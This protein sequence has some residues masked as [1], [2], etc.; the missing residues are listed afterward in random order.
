MNNEPKHSEEPNSLNG[1]EKTDTPTPQYIVANVHSQS[2]GLFKTLGTLGSENLNVDLNG[3]YK[4]EQ[5]DVKHEF[6]VGN[7]QAEQI[8]QCDNDQDDIS[9]KDEPIDSPHSGDHFESTLVAADLESL[10]IKEEDCDSRDGVPSPIDE[11]QTETGYDNQDNNDITDLILLGDDT[12]DISNL[13]CANIATNNISSVP[14]KLS[15]H[16]RK[17]AETTRST[18][19]ELSS[20]LSGSEDEYRDSESVDDSFDDEDYR[21]EEDIDSEEENIEWS[22]GLA[23]SSDS[24]VNVEDDWEWDSPVRQ[25]I[26]SNIVQKCTKIN[27]YVRVEKCISVKTKNYVEES[28]LQKYSSTCGNT[29]VHKLSPQMQKFSPQMQTLQKHAYTHVQK[30]GPKMQKSSL[31]MQKSNSQVQ[32]STEL[33]DL[34]SSYPRLKLQNST[35]HRGKNP[36]EHRALSQCCFN[37]E[38]ASEMVDQNLTNI[39]SSTM[40]GV[41]RDVSQAP[42]KYNSK[43]PANKFKPQINK[44]VRYSRVEKCIS[45]EVPAQIQPQRRKSS[46]LFD[47]PKLK[48]RPVVV[49]EHNLITDMY[50]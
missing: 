43:V 49:I 7:D 37:V 10:Y 31:Q 40:S 22:K 9:V 29:H 5:L 14:N 15:R 23:E 13:P 21:P 8:E 47:D 12:Y 2:G 45:A 44:T 4:S 16:K 39:G 35:Q 17:A 24:D 6:D 11:F 32:K 33:A 19:N 46:N 27:K 28:T 34:Q 20:Y 18:S 1:L 42:H 36:S 48:M 38:L 50:V 26:S 25:L 3:C 30:L 41:C